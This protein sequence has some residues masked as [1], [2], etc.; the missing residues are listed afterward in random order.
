M[1]P[2]TRAVIAALDAADSRPAVERVAATMAAE[3]GATVRPVHVVTGTG[4]R[5]PAREAALHRVL[6]G[7]T[8]RVVG[9]PSDVIALLAASPAVDLVVLGSPTSPAPAGH[10]GGGTAFAVAR[11]V[12]RPVL[13][14]PPTAT[15]WAG[16][17]RV[18][19]P[20]DGSAEA[21]LAAAAAVG[22]LGGSR[23]EVVS[24]RLEAPST[25]AAGLGAI[26]GMV[27]EVH[28]DLAVLVWDRR[29]LA[30]R[31]LAAELASASPVPLLLVPVGYR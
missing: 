31:A 26:L 9:R 6:G 17:R 5:G 13:L 10:R 7:S 21:A 23:W 8:R 28:A 16:P 22:G 19:V 4:P 11:R 20:L 29:R 30:D 24:R 12:R 3:L 15:G 27:D 2:S 1:P 14:A 18:L 25:P